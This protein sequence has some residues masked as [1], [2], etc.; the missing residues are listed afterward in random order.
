MIVGC[1]PSRA[2][3]STTREKGEAT[4]RAAASPPPALIPIAAAG[5][6]PLP[7]G[8][9][10]RVAACGERGE[11]GDRCVRRRRPR[12]SAPLLS[13]SAP[14]RWSRGVRRA[15]RGRGRVGGARTEALR[16]RGSPA[17]R[18]SSWRTPHPLL[19][20]AATALLAIDLP[21]RFSPQ[22][23]PTWAD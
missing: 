8:A 6:S 18:C 7:I 1:R 9:S 10:G 13:P 19:L 14:A 20:A 17:M 11:G 12:P 16:R 22:I 23:V 15:R 4:G 3:S 2:G 21:R 5:S